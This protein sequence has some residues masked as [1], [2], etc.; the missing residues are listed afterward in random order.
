M[1]NWNAILD[2]KL[3]KAG[4]DASGSD[5][6]AGRAHLV[7][8]FRLD[9]LG[10]EMWTWLINSRSDQM[11]TYL[12][13]GRRANRDFIT[14]PT[15]HWIRQTDPKLVRVSL[16]LANRPSLAGYWKFNTSLLKIWDFWEWLESLI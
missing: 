9:H 8:R 5:R 12:D 3:D 7:N 1:G 13:N 14:Y 6:L 15:F 10:R 11:Q 2:P 16:R 4:R